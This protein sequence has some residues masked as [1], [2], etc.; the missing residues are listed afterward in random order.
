[1]VVDAKYKPQYNGKNISKEDIRQVSGYAR[2]KSIYKELQMENNYNQVI[3]CLIIYSDQGAGRKDFASA[4]F[5]E[6]TEDNYVQF[7]KIGIELPTLKVNYHT[8]KS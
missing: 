6:E 1:M 3:D 4:D 2:M 5:T 7:Y 8:K